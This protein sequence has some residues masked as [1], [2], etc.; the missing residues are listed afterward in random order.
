MGFEPTYDGFANRCLTA[1][2]AAYELAGLLVALRWI[3][4]ALGVMRAS[5]ERPT[6]GSME[7]S[8][9]IAAVKIG[10]R[11]AR[12]SSPLATFSMCFTHGVPSCRS[13][14]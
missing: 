5:D 3:V 12:E 10:T 11:S 9:P 14:P 13:K 1:W 2:L 6:Q 7:I 4:P 8:F